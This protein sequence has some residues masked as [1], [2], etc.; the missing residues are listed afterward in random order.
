MARLMSRFAV[1]RGALNLGDES[2]MDDFDEN[3]PRAM[4]RLMRQMGEEAGEDLDPEMEHVLSRLEAGDDPEAVMADAG[5]G[6]ADDL[7]DEF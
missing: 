2:A 4:A 1:H 6:T 3:D 5:P 7:G